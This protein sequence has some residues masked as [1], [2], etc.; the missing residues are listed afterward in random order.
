MFLSDYFRKSKSLINS[1]IYVLPLLIIYEFGIFLVSSDDLPSIRNGAD[2]LIRTI[3][4]NIGITGI[5]GLGGVFILI[6]VAVYIINRK[7]SKDLELNSIHFISVLFESLIWAF[8]LYLLLSQSQLLL[9]KDSNQH[10]LQQISLA[11]GSGLFEEF[12]FRVLLLGIIIFILNL[13]IKNKYWYKLSIAVFIVAILFAYFHFIGDY[14]DDTNYVNFM[15]RFIAGIYLGYL[16]AIRGF[17]LVSYTH[18]FYNL[19]VIVQ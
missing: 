1:L 14:A 8:F 5:Y 12:L 4:D 10:T 2:V 16:Y 9:M 17:A 13:V 6:F 3:L 18:S 15:L 11:I 7:K 19:L